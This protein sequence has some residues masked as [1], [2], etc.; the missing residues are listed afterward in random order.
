MLEYT[1]LGRSQHSHFPFLPPFRYP[2]VGEMITGC[3]CR[4]SPAGGIVRARAS[5][6]PREV[7]TYRQGVKVL[8]PFR[9]KV[10]LK[11]KELMA[12]RASLSM[13]VTLEE[14]ERLKELSRWSNGLAP[15]GG[16]TDR[17]T[18]RRKKR[19]VKHPQSST[20]ARETTQMWMLHIR[21][22]M[23]GPKKQFSLVHETL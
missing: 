9:A 15:R 11:W 3:N 14:R 22:Q 19:E 1:A 10:S 4:C 21:Y 7:P 6:V 12:S 18:V 13:L 23:I 17:R 20:I 2:P 16:H 8:S 5:T